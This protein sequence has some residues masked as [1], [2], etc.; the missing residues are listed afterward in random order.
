MLVLFNRT[1]Q[2]QLEQARVFPPQPFMSGKR[3]LNCLSQT[4]WRSLPGRI[5]GLASV[6]D[7][8]RQTFAWHHRRTVGCDL[9]GV[10][11]WSRDPTAE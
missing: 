6:F 3:L 9:R 4:P 5:H 1:F 2:W 7:H 8:S 11:Q 10:Y